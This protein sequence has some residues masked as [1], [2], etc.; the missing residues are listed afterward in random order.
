MAFFQYLD[1]WIALFSI[2]ALIYFVGGDVWREKIAPHLY[3][4]RPERPAASAQRPAPSSPAP[5][6]RIAR[7]RHVQRP[8]NAV[9]GHSGLRT[10]LKPAFSV[11]RS[12]H[13]VQS[14]L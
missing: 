8:L 9:Q 3:S 4:G 2:G 14:C 10:I 11:Q 6:R 12:V 7:R 13:S 5:W 1:F